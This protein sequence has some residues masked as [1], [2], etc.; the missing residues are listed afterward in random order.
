MCSRATAGNVFVFVGALFHA[1]AMFTPWWIITTS[2]YYGLWQFCT[3][4]TESVKC[5]SI[6]LDLSANIVKDSMKATQAIACLGLIMT[7]L[8]VLFTVYYL[9]RSEKLQVAGG[10]SICAGILVMIGVVIFGASRNSLGLASYLSYSF[11]VETVGGLLLCIA[12]GMQV[13]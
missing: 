13:S 4:L 2:A 1:L 9:C 12:G 7:G 6:S 8:A 3:R 5:Q 11:G 10:C